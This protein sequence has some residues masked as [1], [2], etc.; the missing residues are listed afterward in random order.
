MNC[1]ACYRFLNLCLF[2][3]VSMTVS[4][5]SV[6]ARP[7]LHVHT[8]KVLESAPKRKVCKYLYIESVTDSM[9]TV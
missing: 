2:M 7:D 9:Y 8:G 1:P 6:N 3:Q 5:G 4:A